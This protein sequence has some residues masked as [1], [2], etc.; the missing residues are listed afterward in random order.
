MNFSSSVSGSSPSLLISLSSPKLSPSGSL[1]PISD[2]SPSL[3]L[4]SLSTSLSPL[5]LE[6]WNGTT[7]LLNFGLFVSLSESESEGTTFGI[8]GAANNKTIKNANITRVILVSF[9][10]Y[11]PNDAISHPNEIILHLMTRS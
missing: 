8:I 2:S 1:S 6:P 7:T 4:P 3:S 10:F 11:T 5:P 9:L